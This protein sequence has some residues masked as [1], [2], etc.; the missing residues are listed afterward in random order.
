TE[1]SGA[2]SVGILARDFSEALANPKI[3]G[4]VLEIDSPGGEATGINE[5]GKMIAAGA[6]QK[7]VIAYGGGMV[8]SGAYW[9]ASAAGEIV[10]DETAMLGSIGVVITARKRDGSDGTVEIVSS[11]SPNKRVD[12]AKES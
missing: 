3:R 11:Q 2:V 8:A 1:I 9:L 6:R 12:P 4:I 5:L 10:V 7:P